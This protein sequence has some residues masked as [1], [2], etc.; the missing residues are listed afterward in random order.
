[1]FKLTQIANTCIK[2][3]KEC[4]CFLMMKWV[5]PAKIRDNY[6]GEYLEEGVI[7]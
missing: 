3:I 7:S 2:L 1:M 4:C 5:R 6:S